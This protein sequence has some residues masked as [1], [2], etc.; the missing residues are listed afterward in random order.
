MFMEWYCTTKTTSIGCQHYHKT[1]LVSSYCRSIP[2]SKLRS[3]KKRQNP[4]PPQGDKIRFW[5]LHCFS[6]GDED[7]HRLRNLQT[8]GIIWFQDLNSFESSA[9][10]KARRLAPLSPK[11]CLAPLAFWL[12]PNCLSWVPPESTIWSWCGLQ[13]VVS[14][15]QH[16]FH[17]E[18]C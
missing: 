15:E 8:S 10:F 13:V 5:I 12:D 11:W 4:Q 3:K 17:S 16:S 18:I 1:L 7:K 14:G 9:T 2:V 6:A